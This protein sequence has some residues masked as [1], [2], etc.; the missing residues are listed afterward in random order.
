[1]RSC[2]IM[3][4]MCNVCM[5]I[6]FVAYHYGMLLHYLSWIKCVWYTDL[7]TINVA[8]TLVPVVLAL[9]N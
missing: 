5:F 1:M 3:L 4:R 6:V 2:Y 9:V 8:G 7:C